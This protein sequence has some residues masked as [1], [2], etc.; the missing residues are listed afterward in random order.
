MK[1]HVGMVALM[2]SCPDEKGAPPDEGG[3]KPVVAL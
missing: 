1:N 3:L 2:R